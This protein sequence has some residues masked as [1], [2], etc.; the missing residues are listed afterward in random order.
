[1]NP[2]I[3]TPGAPAPDPLQAAL[4][5]LAICCGDRDAVRQCLDEGADPNGCDAT[6]A[7]PLVLAAS[8]GQTQMCDLLLERGAS[9]MLGNRDAQAIRA[10][11]APSRFD[12]LPRYEPMPTYEA[13]SSP[14]MEEAPSVEPP[15]LHEERAMEVEAFSDRAYRIAKA[16]LA[17]NPRARPVRPSAAA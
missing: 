3:E 17:A 16:L 4:L 15:P 14:L 13:P 1:V 5:R 8:L 9:L 7:S 12:I 2:D 10:A 6:G 11:S